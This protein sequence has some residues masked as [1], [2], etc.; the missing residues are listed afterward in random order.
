MAIREF[1]PVGL[2]DE[3]GLLAIGGDVEI[4]S[5]LLAY[6][7]GIFPWPVPGIE[8]LTWFA[9]PTRAVLFLDKFRLPRSLKK[10]ISAGRF[11]TA[12]DQD[13]VAVIRGCADSPNRL[14]GNCTWITEE[15]VEGYATLAAAGYCHSV[16]SYRGITLAGG[17]YGVAIGAMFA[18]E[19][20]FYTEAHAS[21]VALAQLVQHLAERGGKWIDCQQMTPLFEQF[22]AE[23]VSR[24]R[25]TEM[26]Q[27]AIA[28]PI[29]LFD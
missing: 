12:I 3:Y 9:P 18:G 5:L 19:S 10:I 16:E 7:S 17:L 23:E 26:L 27:E 13:T 25:F 2:A 14:H 11:R 22:G 15:M 6:R 8:D 29:C 28:S 21:K 20:M 4:S 24:E 1:P